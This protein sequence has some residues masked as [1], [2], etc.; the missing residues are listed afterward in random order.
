MREAP[1][2]KADDAPADENLARQRR[3]WSTPKLLV[4]ST[5]SAVS[6]LNYSYE[7]SNTSDV[8]PIGPS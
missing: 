6:K 8:Y 1:T 7:H 5:E 4:E 2:L 3:P